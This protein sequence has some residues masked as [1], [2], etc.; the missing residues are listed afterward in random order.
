M[1][2]FSSGLITLLNGL[3]A[4]VG[5]LASPVVVALVLAGLGLAWL[6]R[7][8]IDELNRQSSKPEVGRH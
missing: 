1:E 5:A 3:L 8:E 4:M 2:I 7:L 6:C